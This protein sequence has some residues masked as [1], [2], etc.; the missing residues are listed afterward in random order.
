MMM[1]TLRQGIL[2]FLLTLLVV[3]GCHAGA[4]TPGLSAAGAPGI[5]PDPQAGNVSGLALSENEV[6]FVVASVAGGT[7]DGDRYGNPAT[8]GIIRTH[9]LVYSGTLTR[10]APG[11]VLVQAIIECSPGNATKVYN[12]LMGAITAPRQG[13]S[14]RFQESYG[15]GEKSFAFTTTSGYGPDAS[16]VIRG[17]LFRKGNIVEYIVVMYPEDDLVEM[18]APAR[19]AAAKVPAAGTRPTVVTTPAPTKKPTPPVTP[20]PTIKPTPNGT[21]TQPAPD[22]AKKGLLVWY[23]FED[24][25]L[26]TGVVKDRSGSGRDGVVTGQVNKAD[27]ISGTKGIGFTGNGYLLTKDNPAAGRNQ[28]TFSFWFRTV[29]PTQNYKFASAAE[30][31][32]GPGSGWTMATHIPEFWADDGTDGLLVPGEPNNDNGFIPGTW[33]HEAVVY[34][35][36]TMKEYT[37]GVL[38][39]TWNGRNVPMSKGVPMAVGG[40]PQF[41]GYNYVG[42]MDDFRIYD[43]TLSAKEIA[44]LSKK[45]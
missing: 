19:T 18:T 22:T 42:Q 4:N 24:D 45:M 25:F 8:R 15:I 10:P 7:K 41:S 44:M 9:S 35:G 23:D 6:P 29:D 30:W 5:S 11:K 20:V 40:W 32:G 26:K 16:Y 21:P 38:I 31:R 13:N 12:Y 27:G 1:K 34:D 37:N 39:N 3:S 36:K 14:I 2:V 17:I 33:T 43:Q 28:V